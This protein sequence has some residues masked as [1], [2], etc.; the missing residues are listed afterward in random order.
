[1]TFVEDRSVLSLDSR[2]PDREIRYGED[3]L[4]VADVWES[5]PA[6]GGPLVVL[7]HGGFWRPAFDRKHLGPFA[8]AIADAGFT[9]ASIE[10]RRIPGQP[11]LMTGDVARACRYVPE[12]LGASRAVAIGHSAGGHLALWAA[13]T[14][15]VP[16]PVPDTAI[17]YIGLAPAAS[18]VMAEAQNLGGGAVAAFLGVEARTRRDLDPLEL[19]TPAAQVSIVHGDEDQIVPKSLSEAYQ[20]KHPATR[21]VCVPNAGHFALID[22]RAH[23]W[24]TILAEIERLS[25][26]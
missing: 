21:L 11:D 5:R 10:Y 26:G 14:V 20:S 1:M 22:P 24:T 13:A 6:V 12:L 3:P 23:A 2:A 19:P 25:K 9:V 7:I 4:H 8:N 16:V 15:P 18:L 17:S